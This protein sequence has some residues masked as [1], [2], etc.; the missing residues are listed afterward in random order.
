M[1]TLKRKE[2]ETKEV[3]ISR[4]FN[5]ESAPGHMLDTSKNPGLQPSQL[6]GCTPPKEGGGYTGNGQAE[7]GTTTP[8]QQIGGTEGHQCNQEIL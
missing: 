2:T 1:Q 4:R 8:W 6:L 3:K 5:T 7:S